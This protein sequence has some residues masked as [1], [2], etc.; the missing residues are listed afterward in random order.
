MSV[1]R[2]LMDQDRI[3]VVN[4]PVLCFQTFSKKQKEL[5]VILVRSNF[6]ILNRRFVFLLDFIF[7]DFKKA[8]I[9]IDF[10]FVSL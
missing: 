9:Y 6:G 3:R 5:C 2:L 8:R 1:L 4:H 7:Y 10:L